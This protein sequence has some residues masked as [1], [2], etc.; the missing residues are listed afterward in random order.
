MTRSQHYWGVKPLMALGLACAVTLLGGCAGGAKVEVPVQRFEAAMQAGSDKYASGDLQLAATAFEQAERIAA[1][2]DR[3]ALRV[4]ALLA[5]GAVFATREQEA[6]ALLAYQRA[7]AE[8]QS[9]ADSHTVGV[10]WA[11]IADVQRRSGELTGALQSFE[12]ALQPQALRE[13]ST[14]RMQA[15]MGQ[16]LVWHAQGRSAAAREAF[17]GLEEQIR[18]AH[19]SLLSGVLANQAVVLRDAGEVAAAVAKAEEAL[20]LDRR[21]ASPTALAADLE[22]LG[23]LYLAAQRPADAKASW[24]R[25]Q[26]IV[27]T[28]GQAK[29]GKRLAALLQELSS[30]Q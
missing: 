25:A 12:K 19:P 13:G 9:L 24:E 6:E 26:R 28:T 22:L 3:R 20:A 1:L 16:A 5:S 2:Y 18:T 8:A 30:R 17:Q 4:Q 23:R 29:A 15:R 14:E 21:A 7:L 10:A 11:G 27:Q